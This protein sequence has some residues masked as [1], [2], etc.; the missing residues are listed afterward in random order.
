MGWFKV[1]KIFNNVNNSNKDRWGNAD[2]GPGATLADKEW[3]QTHHGYANLRIDVSYDGS[4]W[5][6]IQ[7]NGSDEYI[8]RWVDGLRLYPKFAGGVWN[9]EGELKWDYLDDIYQVPFYALAKGGGPARFRFSEEKFS[10]LDRVG[11]IR[12]YGWMS[13]GTYVSSQR[14]GE[15]ATTVNPNGDAVI[16]DNG[17]S[18]VVENTY[19]P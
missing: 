1:K 12:T 15:L 19:Y 6:R 7:G 9:Q 10:N 3:A 14:F 4:S 13:N 2:L 11:Y 5:Q 8:G 18:V 17:G 16:I